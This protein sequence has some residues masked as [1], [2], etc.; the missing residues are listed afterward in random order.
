MLQRIGAVGG[1][2]AAAGAMQSMGWFGVAN[3]R[4]LPD[5]PADLGRG[6]TVVVLGAGFA[7]LVA[8]YELEQRGFSVTVLEARNRVGGKAWTVRDGD[9]VEMVGEQP[10]TARFSEGLY[11]NAGP[12]R[13]PSFHQ[14]VLGYAKRFGVPL[15]VEVNSSRSAYLVARNG[16]RLRMRTAV[17]D[18][19]GHVAELLA[20]AVNQGALDQALSLDEKAKL[21]PFLK[22][23]GDLEDGYAF[24]GTTRSGFKT[25][26]GAGISSFETPSEPVPLADLLANEQ[27]AMMG[28]DDNLYMQATMFQPVGGMDQ[29]PLGIERNLKRRVVLDAEVRQ[30]RQSPT[31]VDTAYIDTRSGSAQTISADYCVCTIPFPVLAKIDA[32]FSRPVAEAIAGV[33][34][35]DSNKIAFDAPRFWEQDQIYG[36]LTFVGGETSLIWY[37]SWGMHSERGMIVGCYSSGEPGRAFARR[38]IAE[39]I[40]MARAA[41]ERVHPGHGADCSAPLA[42]NWKKVPHSLGP[43]PNWTPDRRPR[44]HA[45]TDTPAYRLLCQPEGRILFASAALSQTPGWQEGALQSAHAGVAALV[46]QMADRNVTERRRAMV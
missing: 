31:G 30:I 44:E 43:W 10:Q 13:L 18:M 14:G 25:G 41:I 45:A 36:G 34:Y 22:A 27:L 16:S 1:I 33:V 7:G 11:F 35:D 42:V 15:E 6:H 20:K 26:P 37:P 24:K 5:M 38:P 9:T 19:R 4:P 29:I 8:A 39:Q 40:A 2:A 12:A 32:N 21:L 46:Q 17:N 3:A 23:Y 28:F